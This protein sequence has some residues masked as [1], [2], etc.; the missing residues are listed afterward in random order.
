MSATEVVA[1][2]LVAG[3]ET[4]DSDQKIK[5]LKE[6]SAF[7][8]ANDDYVALL[9]NFIEEVIGFADDREP[10][11]QG[12]VV[13]FLA[14]AARVQSRFST[15]VLQHYAT[16]WDT[17]NSPDSDYA[18][19]VKRAISGMVVVFRSGLR[20][21]AKQ[22]SSSEATE[23]LKALLYEAEDKST[24]FLESENPGQ[25]LAA[26]KASETYVMSLSYKTK[27]SM[28]SPDDTISLDDI[29]PQGVLDIEFLRERGLKHFRR[30]VRTLRAKRITSM[31]MV[32]L[33]YTLGTLARKRPKFMKD[34]TEAFLAVPA[35]LPEEFTTAQKKACTKAIKLQVG[36][37]IIHP[38]GGGALLDL[39][40]KVLSALGLRS[41][42]V[43]RLIRSRPPDLDEV[44]T[45]QVQAKRMEELRH[46]PSARKIEQAKD[47]AP[48]RDLTK[49]VRNVDQGGRLATD[50]VLQHIGQM[51]DTFP[52]K[53][54]D[55]WPPTV[56]QEF[57][58][59]D[60]ERATIMALSIMSHMMVD[61]TEQGT[62]PTGQFTYEGYGHGH[63]KT[64][65]KGQEEKQ[66]EVLPKSF[67]LVDERDDVLTSPVLGPG[68][69]VPDITGL[70]KGILGEAA[71]KV[72]LEEGSMLEEQEQPKKSGR[73]RKIEEDET[74]PEVVPK[75]QAAAGRG[76]A[77]KVS[78]LDDEFKLE[79][80]MEAVNRIIDTCK[81]AHQGAKAGAGG[82]QATE[83]E[84]GYS[85]V[86]KLGNGL[87]QSLV[88][89]A[90]PL[91]ED[92]RVANRFAKYVTGKLRYHMELAK[93]F[94]LLEYE[95][96]TLR[97]S[98]DRYDRVLSALLGRMVGQHIRSSAMGTSGQTLLS[99]FL[100]TA[101]R[102]APGSAQ[103]LADG[104][105]EAITSKDLQ[106]A[107]GDTLDD[108][109][110]LT[111]HKYILDA[112]KDF[113]IFR[114]PAREQAM[115]AI[116][117][118]ACHM[119]PRVRISAIQV[120]RDLHKSLQNEELV[121]RIEQAA[122]SH[123]QAVL[124]FGESTDGD[125]MAQ[126]Y[127]DGNEPSPAA[128]GDE[129]PSPPA[130][131]D[132]E[133]GDKAEGGEGGEKMV[134]HANRK[135]GLMVDAEGAG[136]DAMEGQ[137]TEA[138][139]AEL[140]QKWNS[141]RVKWHL[142]FFMALVPSKPKLL[143]EEGIFFRVF[144]EAPRFGR[145]TI[146]E[147]LLACTG[148]IGNENE[149]LM[150]VLLAIP[151]SCRSM[152]FYLISALSRNFTPSKVFE[153]T[154]HLLHTRTG[155]ARFLIPL[156]PHMAPDEVRRWLPEFLTMDSLDHVKTAVQTI[157]RAGAND[158]ACM[159]PATLMVEIATMNE[160]GK[161]DSKTSMR[162]DDEEQQEV[163][164]ERI[165]QAL[166][167]C[168]ELSSVVNQSV[169][170]VVLQQLSS[171]Q[172]LP[173]LMMRLIIQSVKI[174]PK[175]LSFVCNT[176]MIKLIQREIW[177]NRQLW[178]GFVRFCLDPSNHPHTYFVLMSLPPE[179]LHEVLRSGKQGS[180][181]GRALQSFLKQ[182]NA[183]QEGRIPLATRRMIM[184]G[185]Y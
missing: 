31:N 134:E 46:L 143:M 124:E 35:H 20:Q 169:I 141:D 166:N 132:E 19:V 55:A 129:A 172:P 23:E 16:L 90:W 160:K 67:I 114:P 177:T 54:E 103:T 99:E 33:I 142:Q 47:L 40:A 165:A 87:L 3:A 128:D 71:S 62:K 131:E 24:G 111:A 158:P 155:D 36:L 48:V 65:F 94:I 182:S 13:D 147:L 25:R 57:F 156:V 68:N 88:V 109:E 174:A 89:R 30:L 9:D 133:L 85:G 139:E 154:V 17:Y 91:D 21:L 45:P 163:P 42:E 2:L 22:R 8:Y 27:E 176:I 116:V 70:A 130:D 138:Q 69:E 102:I 149:D 105:I 121:A 26:I 159:K 119:A 86:E 18:I 171:F 11:V 1:A 74:K 126:D 120:M 178:E 15:R 39:F 185:R 10:T 98:F 148:I 146:K 82:M 97:D 104:S 162:D 51:P 76:F 41:S 34:V 14:Q 100:N 83:G 79:L 151:D 117:Q 137:L 95:S 6:A 64:L 184:R 77:L 153:E 66:A 107:G 63:G 80:Y 145:D 73:K 180:H 81:E 168:F 43:D 179:Q 122:T 173:V 125:A 123:L 106:G 93:S 44:V 144:E 49:I 4:T 5:C 167:Y 84:E 72:K 101:P 7:I 136:D 150:E 108:K 52:Q 152:A 127:A 32:A 78:P 59:P 183:D 112:L 113:I 58:G 118:L 181:V 53:F 56:G 38:S 12:F 115:E 92:I 110:R 50:I 29:P 135:E 61:D 170:A 37:F 96:G 164:L 140:L 28:E 161:R 157:L 60:V 75:K 175:L